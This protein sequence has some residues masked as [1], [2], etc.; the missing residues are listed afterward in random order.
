MIFSTDTLAWMRVK[1]WKSLMA[2]YLLPPS[3]RPGS[4]PHCSSGSMHDIY[5][6]ILFS[7]FYPHRYL[8]LSHYQHHIADLDQ[9]FHWAAVLSYNV[10]YWHECDVHHVPFSTFDQ[11]LY[12]TTLNAM[13]AKV[14]AH[15]CFWCQHFHHEVANCPFPPGALLEK[16][17]PMKKA[18][19]SQ[20]GQEIN[21]G[22]SSIVP[23]PGAPALSCPLSTNQGREICIKLQSNS[24]SFPNCRRVHVC[25]HCK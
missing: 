3:A 24:C 1:P 10:Q 12:I 19:Q 22:T 8:E 5:M 7:V 2:S 17:M 16:D 11:Q 25:R 21:T 6:R 9:H 18:V 15:R 4:C 20:Q 23:P 14:S 13:A